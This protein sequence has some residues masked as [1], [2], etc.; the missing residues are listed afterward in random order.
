MSAGAGPAGCS[1]RWPAPP[2]GP[3]PCRR[4]RQVMHAVLGLPAHDRAGRVDLGAQ[5]AGQV[6]VPEGQLGGVD[7]DAIGLVH[8]TGGFLVLDVV[9]VQFLA[10][11][12]PGAVA[13]GFVQQRRFGLQ[14]AHH[15]RP[16]GDVEMPA[17]LRLAVELAGQDQLAKHVEGLGD[18]DVHLLGDVDAPALDPLRA[19]Q[20]ARGDLRLSAVAGAAAP[21][22]GVGLQDRGLDAVLLGQVDGTGQTGVAGPDHHHVDVDVALDRAVVFRRRAGGADPV[23]RGVVAIVA[24]AGIDQR[25]VERVVAVARPVAGPNSLWHVRDLQAARANPGPVSGRVLDAALCNGGAI[26]GSRRIVLV[27]NRRKSG[28]SGKNLVYDPIGR[29]YRRVSRRRPGRDRRRRGARGLPPRRSS[30]FSWPPSWRCR[31]S[32]GSSLAP[33]WATWWLVW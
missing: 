5:L 10:A 19:L 26:G 31:C 9:A 14:H 27:Q 18:L 24:G 33:P 29:A 11:H 2:C 22:D 4:R 1:R 15:A 30:S 7:R 28:T 12:D 21:A 13:E 32:G 17:A 20:A 16:M 3:G 23:G 6:E 8:G 25:V